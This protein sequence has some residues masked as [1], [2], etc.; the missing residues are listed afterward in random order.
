MLKSVVEFFGTE[1]YTKFHIQYKSIRTLDEH[2]VHLKKHSL[3][4][5]VNK[6]ECPL[7]VPQALDLASQLL[8]FD[9]ARRPSAKRALEHE[10]FNL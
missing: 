3:T 10:F 6:A 1:E 7:A 2:C 5:L 8:T 9:F 4:E